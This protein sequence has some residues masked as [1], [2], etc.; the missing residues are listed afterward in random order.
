MTDLSIVGMGP[1]DPAYI[2]PQAVTCIEEADVLIGGE[3]HLEACG[4]EGKTLIPLQGD[5]GSVIRRALLEHPA[6]RLAVLVS[7]DPC[8]HSPL[9]LIREQFP[10][11]PIAIIPGLSSFQYLFSRIG[12]PW[13]GSRLLSLH[14]SL[15][16]S[17]EELLDDER[18]VLLLDREHTP[19]RVAG[20]LCEH[21][22][23]ERVVVIGSDLS[24]EA[25]EILQMTAAEV[26]EEEYRLCVMILL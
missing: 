6:Q 24:Y 13:Q 4:G 12:L 9:R 14:G 21:D 2:L 1:G 19:S 11:I 7:G 22:Q 5:Y 23:G 17:W 3:R 20:Y 26:P 15:P 8:Y 18:T 16:E 10:G 25:E